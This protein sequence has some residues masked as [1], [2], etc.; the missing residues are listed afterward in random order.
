MIR[1]LFNNARKIVIK[2]GSNTLAGSDGRINDALLA[3]F[4]E[5]AAALI[6]EG[7]QIAIVSS[8]AQLAGLSAMDKWERKRDLHYRQALCAVGQVKLMNAWE[9][10][11]A[12]QG[13]QIAQI[14]LTRNDF[15]DNT[16]TLNMRNTLFTLVDEGVVPIINENDTVSVEEIK[17]GDNDTLAAQSAILWSA[18][19]L[20]LFSDID[21]LYDKNPREH[22]DAKIISEVRD[23][24]A[25]RQS[26]SS[27]GKTGGSVR[28]DGGAGEF[29]TG[30]IITKLDAAERAVSYGIPMI[31][32]HGG[33]KRAL[34]ALAAGTGQGTAFLVG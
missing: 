31:L 15:A 25:A 12:P 18:D 14:L 7:K 22:P 24:K 33:R 21:G 30:G 8:G 13:I 29:G 5:Q 16:R 17:I 4:A 1:E 11:F 3:E 28:D 23:I 34:E 32:A 20:V 6:K 10:A 19:L 26:A 2:F 9:R 27:A